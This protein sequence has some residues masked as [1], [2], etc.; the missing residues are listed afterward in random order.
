M[1]GEFDQNDILIS[2]VYH[3]P[4]HPIYGL[5]E[6]KKDHH[7]RKPQPGMVHMATKD[8]GLN[9]SKS[10]LIGDKHTDIQAGQSAGIKTNILFDRNSEYTFRHAKNYHIITELLDAEFLL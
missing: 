4:Y 9:L 8:Y 7:T 1:C 2:K 10:V 5:G 3:S 6:Y